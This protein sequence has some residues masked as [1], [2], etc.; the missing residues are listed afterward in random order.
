M[1]FN[2]GVPAFRVNANYIFLETQQ[3]SEFSGREEISYGAS[4][5]LNRFWRVGLTGLTDLAAGETRRIGG[6]I[7]Y[8]NE[9]LV[10]NAN[11]SRTFF[12]DRDL[13][14]TDTIT[15]NFLLKTLGPIRADVFS[16]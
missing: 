3:G 16:Q 10:F 12:E 15:F 14:P 2:A 7:T 11:L 5:R 9:C 13:E 4:S 6:N 1:S 8:E